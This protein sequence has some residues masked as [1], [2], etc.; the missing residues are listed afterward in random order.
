MPRITVTNIGMA[1]NLDIALVRTF[2][3][4]ADHASMTMAGT[5]LH[6]TQ[7]AV[8]QQIA[9][10]EDL[11]GP[12]FLREHRRLRLTPLGERL[13]TKARRLIALNDELWSEMTPAALSAPVRLGAPQ[14]LVATWLPPIL[15]G[16]A[17]AHPRVEIALTCMAS[18][19]LLDAVAKGAVDLA[20]IEE[21]TGPTP[22]T[23]LMVDRLVW[24]GARGGTAHLK[25]PLPVSLVAKTCAFRP[26]VLDALD[27][28]GVVWRTLYD[29]GS[30]DATSAT[31][32][33]DLAVTT[34]LA[35]T[36]PEDL[37]ILPAD[38][39]LP[40][41]PRFAVNL[42]RRKRGGTQTAVELERHIRRELGEA[43][44]AA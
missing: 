38:A 4:A 6:I 36:V 40:T 18:P 3:A 35:S 37:V 21:P 16:F 41:L 39:G 17:E 34:W 43:H 9:R 33:A 19:D 2:V 30:I 13:L 5:A 7:S 24:V 25:T 10:L 29:S 8:S 15:K 14:D 28:H 23:C 20:L 1:R 31:V 11:A 32:R 26:V 27:A 42:Y 44:V 22:G 12:L